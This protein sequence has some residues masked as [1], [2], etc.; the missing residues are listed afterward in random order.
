MKAKRFTAAS[1][2]S[3]L[4][5][6]TQELGADALIISTKK[7]AT[8]IEVLAARDGAEPAP[9]PAVRS[10]EDLVRALTA[11]KERQKPESNAAPRQVRTPSKLAA[12]KWN[13]HQ[14]AQ[15]ASTPMPLKNAAKNTQD[16]ALAQ[17]QTE[18][19]ELK[20]LLLQQQKSEVKTLPLLSAKLK[21]ELGEHCQSLGLL[22]AWRDKLLEQA[23]GADFDSAKT[24]LDKKML[25]DLPIS[26]Y[27]ILDRGGI[28]ALVGPTGAGKTT[29]IGKIAAHFVMRNG[30]KAVALVTMDNYRVAA[31]D[32]LR[33]FARILGVDFKIVPANGS[34]NKVLDE[35]KDKKL[36]LVDSAGL[37]SQ[38]P[39]F[40]AQMTLLKSSARVRKLLV[41][42]LTN[43]SRS[44]E[45]TYQLFKPLVLSGCI[46]TKLDECFS[47]GAALSVAALSFLPITLVTDGP[48]IP[49]DIH[50]PEAQK[51]LKASEKMGQLARSNWQDQ[52]QIA[53]FR[54]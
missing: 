41:L 16:Q 50:Y 32:Q 48:H 13:S 4:R 43:H 19:Q 3:A 25:Q 15:P 38:D 21:A 6:V 33:A 30:P 12:E 49:D 35:L 39:H 46:F 22:P 8:G 17:M 11:F 54:A 20:K 5:L 36:V 24:L 31:H 18:I 53:N 45:E 29:T 9:V 52:K 51:L 14:T 28:F 34:L 1:M 40:E 23:Q 26:S 37:N 47:L 2:Q 42:P 10:H 27:K 44:L 7:L